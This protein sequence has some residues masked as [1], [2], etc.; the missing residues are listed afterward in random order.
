MT[1]L[2]ALRPPAGFD[3]LPEF[4]NGWRIDGGAEPFLAYEQ[5]TDLNWSAEL[6]ELHEESSRDHFIDVLTR[7]ALLRGIRPALGRNALVVDVGCSSGYLLA[8][9]RAEHAAATIVGV[10]LVAEGLRRA[11][12][13]VP[14]APLLLADCL[15]LPFDDAS[16]AAIASA[17]VLE[18]IA[19][20]EGA[21][22]EMARILRPG[23]LAAVVVP[24]GPGLF[25]AYDEHLGHERRYARKELARRGERAGL[26]V[27]EDAYLGSLLFPPF[28]ATKKL[29]RRRQRDLNNEQRADLVERDIART[30]GSK[31][32]DAASALERGM[33][34]RGLRIPFGIRSLAV[35]RRPV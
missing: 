13:E 14:D 32:G 4:D 22:R 18:H 2:A 9:L 33:L 7:W 30:Q 17:N 12:A 24:A 8:D 31:L 16:V 19:D 25:D 23:G 21:L 3:A 20:D 1:V 6:E 28:W 26:E 34:T 10:D 5:V 35:F 15:A 27:L 11:H 29:H